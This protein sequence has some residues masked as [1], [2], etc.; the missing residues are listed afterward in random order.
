MYTPPI[1]SPFFES[2]VPLPTKNPMLPTVKVPP[3]FVR[4]NREWVQWVTNIARATG[5][6]AQSISVVATLDFGNLAAGAS[7]DL[8]VTVEGVKANDPQPIVDIG[9]GLFTAGL[10]FRG[11]VSADDT[12]TVRCT[13]ASTGAIDPASAIYR[14]EVRRYA[15]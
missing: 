15:P 1:R 12:V 7:A 6:P 9:T 3:R 2:E 14:V 10:V 8:T 4:T 11:F 5:S 13:N